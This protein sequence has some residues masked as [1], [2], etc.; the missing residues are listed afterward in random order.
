MV[1]SKLPQSISLKANPH[2][3][4]GPVGVAEAEVRY[5]PDDQTRASLV[6]TGEVQLASTLSANQLSTLQADKKLVIMSQPIPRF[7]ALYFNNKRAPFTD[8]RVRQAIQSAL[9]A[10]AIASTV[11]GAQAA[12]GP[13]NSTDPWASADQR[14]VP[15]DLARAAGVDAKKLSL[16]L[17]TYSDRAELPRAA[18]VIQ[19]MLAKLGITMKIKV[20]T[21]N[22]VEP[23]MLSGKFDVA[24]V[25]RNYMFYAPDPLS[26]LASDYTCDGTYNISQ[27]CDRS[28]DAEVKRAGTITNA[29]QRYAIYQHVAQ[30]LQNDAVDVFLYHVLQ[31]TA[32]S[33]NLRG[34]QIHTTEEYYL[35]PTIRLAAE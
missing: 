25:S 33:K 31:L 8:V 5:I 13:F 24:L 16:E 2:Y 3:W 29:Q 34:F 32:R 22:A 1:A 35:T 9:D 11:G 15:Y 17:L 10:K 14:V 27:L 12:A 7:T 4:G 30:K 20:A 21:Y 19:E 23:D 28:V 26:F 6:Q 18:T